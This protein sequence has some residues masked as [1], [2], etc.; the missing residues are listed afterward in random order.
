MVRGSK[1]AGF[2]EPGQLQSGTNGQEVIDL[3]LSADRLAVDRDLFQAALLTKSGQGQFTCWGV[4]KTVL[5][6]TGV[7]RPAIYGHIPKATVRFEPCHRIAAFGLEILPA[8]EL[9]NTHFHR[10]LL[11]PVAHPPQ[12]EL[13]K[14]TA[15]VQ[16]A[17]LLV[18]GP[19]HTSGRHL[20]PTDKLP[21][22]EG[23]LQDLAIK[24]YQRR[25]A[26]PGI[27]WR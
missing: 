22:P 21:L 15:G 13:S 24:G 11:T 1:K 17:C 18:T 16:G 19:E 7:H 14:E 8:I 20:A 12:V 23:S 5:H 4:R 9:S 25:D 27:L 3:C 2:F 10:H 6:L 26:R